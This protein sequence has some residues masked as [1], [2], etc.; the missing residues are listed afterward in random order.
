MNSNAKFDLTSFLTTLCRVLY[1]VT[2]RE[3]ERGR[4][5]H[6]NNRSKVAFIV[7]DYPFFSF[8]KLYN[9]LISQTQT[10]YEVF[11]EVYS[12]FNHTLSVYLTGFTKKRRQIS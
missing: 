6:R 2:G 10:I 4:I 11:R 3:L 1:L 7:P 12:F 8:S 9:R 5:M